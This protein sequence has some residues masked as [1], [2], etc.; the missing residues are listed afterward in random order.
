MV[1]DIL[2]DILGEI[3]SEGRSMYTVEDDA[4]LF[5]TPRMKTAVDAYFS[6]EAGHVTEVSSLYGVEI[7]VDGE[8]VRDGEAF[9]IEWGEEQ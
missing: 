2:E 1:E 7:I 3:V 5:L 8:V 4:V 9:R 6:E